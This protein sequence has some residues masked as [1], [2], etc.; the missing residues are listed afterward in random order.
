M[1]ARVIDDDTRF[2]LMRDT[3][4][5]MLKGPWRLLLIGGQ[6]AVVRDTDGLVRPWHM[7]DT[8]WME[9]PNTVPRPAA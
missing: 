7:V 6:L 8:L 4:H 9:D 3:Q 5:L 2:A 1:R